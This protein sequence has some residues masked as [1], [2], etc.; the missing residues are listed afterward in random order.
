MYTGF[1]VELFEFKIFWASSRELDINGFESFDSDNR[2]VVTE[3]G[4]AV[5]LWRF[6]ILRDSSIELDINA[7]ASVEN[8][9]PVIWSKAQII[10]EL[11]LAIYLYELLQ[12][13]KLAFL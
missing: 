3:I 11:L 9:K 1:E 12:T 4:V 6:H 10:K 5:E 2:R 7:F 8:S 13:L